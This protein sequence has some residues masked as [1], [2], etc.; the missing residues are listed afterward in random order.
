MIIVEPPSARYELGG[1]AI[2]TDEHLLERISAAENRISRLTER[3]DRSLDLLLRHAQN[4]YVDRS[5]VKALIAL[6][7]DDGFVETERLEKLWNERCTQDAL[8]QQETIRRDEIRLGILGHSNVDNR[9]AFEDLV[10]RGFSLLNGKQVSRGVAKLQR[11]A[12]M[13]GASSQLSLFLG[14]HFFRTG[15]TRQ[16]RT[17]LARAHDSMP[18]DAGISLLL[19]L[20]C[21][22]DGDIER[23]KE[24]LHEATT[25]GGSCFS[26]HYGLGCVFLAEN[27][28]RHALEEFKRALSTKPSPEAHYVLGCLYYQ[29]NHNT[30]AVRH[31]RKATEMD[32]G[33][34]EAFQL[35]AMA[36]QRAGRKSLVAETL[37]KVMT[38]ELERSRS[39]FSKSQSAKSVIIQPLFSDSTGRSSRLMTGVDRRLA[40]A[41]KE[42]ALRAFK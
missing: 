8:D 6:L 19:G 27:D 17:Y 25:R 42:D 3:L 15:K 22:D 37:D 33:Y 21:A 36:Y 18:D 31:L 1:A 28:Y 5:L 16:A 7:T 35:L 4:T 10:N 20:A 13:T 40:A 34:C 23:A 12:D 29:R 2:S 24:L 41:L 38:L 14:E 32:P 11:A 26:G 39:Q 9:T 30:L